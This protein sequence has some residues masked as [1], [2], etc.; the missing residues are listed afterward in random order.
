MANTKS[1]K[2]K[3]R[4]I[5]RKTE[6][7]RRRKSEYRTY[8]KR[9]EK[10]IEANDVEKAK[11]LLRIVEKKL[12]KAANKGTIHKKAASRKV[13]RLAKKVNNIA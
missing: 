5:N 7:N 13:S 10:A 12:Y 11:E 1:A 8:I 3:I 2:K 9:L 6:V 4:V